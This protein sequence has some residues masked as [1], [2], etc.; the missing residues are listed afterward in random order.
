[1]KKVFLIIALIGLFF[2]MEACK[3]DPV[4][5]DP[6]FDMLSDKNYVV[7]RDTAEEFM[8]R[9]NI[10][11]PAGIEVIQILDG[12]TYD[13]LEELTTYKGQTN[14]LFQHPIR[15]DN[16]DKNQDSVLMYNVRIVT[17]DSRAFNSSFKIDLKKLSRPELALVSG[18]I[19]GTCAPVVGIKGIVETGIYKLQ[20]IKILIDGNER[21]SVP[22]AEIKDSTHFKLDANVTYNFE[23]GK[24]YPVEIVVCDER[25]ETCREEL[26][27][28]G[29]KMKKAVKINM[30]RDEEQYATYDIGYDE[31]G[32]IIKITYECPD[33]TSDS[34]I[35]EIFY[36]EDSSVAETKYYFHQDPTFKTQVFMTFTYDVEGFLEKAIHW[37]IPDPS[38]PE[39][40]K[41]YAVLQNF[42]Y[43][44]DGT[45]Q[46]FDN[47]ITTYDDIQYADGFFEGEKIFAE[48]WKQSPEYMTLGVRRIK[49]GFVPV[50]NPLY[51][52]GLPKVWTARW[53]GENK[54]ADL[55]WYKYV[56]TETAPGPNN[57]EGLSYWIQYAYTCGEDGQLATFT[58][59][60]YAGSYWYKYSYVYEEDLEKEENK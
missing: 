8:L 23:T 50:L 49:K 29:I 21:Y 55:F 44:S 57:T 25:G 36:N 33:Y 24:E 39:T 53:F 27:V 42:K 51:I 48:S 54:L 43:R 16:I 38:D 11:A 60:E 41:E 28:K 26:T 35:M 1:M 46:S 45:I 34:F 18:K 40:K 5:P 7:R 6:G 13:L 47:G 52:E 59:K 4:F 10:N 15:F 9:L 31:Q 37:V 32:R 19:I 14:F 20:S 30:A 56:Y 2:A 12:R 22:E 17:Q 3:D 58:R